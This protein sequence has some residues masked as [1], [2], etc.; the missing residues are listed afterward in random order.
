M[1]EV[2]AQPD[3]IFGRRRKVVTEFKPP[4]ADPEGVIT[5]LRLQRAV[6]SEDVQFVWNSSRAF[7][8]NTYTHGFFTAARGQNG[9][10]FTRHGRTS[11][12]VVAVHPFPRG[13]VIET[14]FGVSVL[15]S[16]RLH[17]LVDDEPMTV[18][19]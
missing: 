12:R 19:R 7:F 3:D 16:G 13:W 1:E 5:E 15:A 8:V 14:D 17:S 4:S 18:P 6:P 9:L 11:G 2:E 10:R